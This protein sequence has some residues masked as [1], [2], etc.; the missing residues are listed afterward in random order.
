MLSERSSPA[1]TPERRAD[2]LAEPPRFEATRV[3]PVTRPMLRAGC[4]SFQVM[5]VELAQRLMVVVLA[6]LERWEAG[7]NMRLAV[8][9]GH[10]TAGG[11]PS[12]PQDEDPSP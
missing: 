7:V 8:R 11:G 9:D 6:R 12:P 2:W 5:G 4:E 1:S 10:V 3:A